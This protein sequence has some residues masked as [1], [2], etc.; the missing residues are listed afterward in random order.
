MLKRSIMLIYILLFTGWSQPCLAHTI[1]YGRYH[2][3][4]PNHKPVFIKQNTDAVV[5]VEN[6]Q[7]PGF[8]P[9]SYIII[10]NCSFFSGI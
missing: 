6:I 4:I 9:A 10:W 8:L 1:Q 2:L 3:E 5:A 7:M